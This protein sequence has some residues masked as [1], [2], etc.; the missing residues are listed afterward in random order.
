MEPRCR[1]DC[2]AGP[3]ERAAPRATPP[4]GVVPAADVTY[5]DLYRATDV[6]PPSCDGYRA[7][8]E[9]T[10]GTHFFE[11]KS[12]MKI[13]YSMAA[14]AVV[15]LMAAS[16]LHAADAPALKCPVSGQ[17]AKADKTADFNGG[18]VQFCCEKCPVA[19][20]KDSAKYAGKANLQLVQT[21]QLKQVKCPLTGKAINPEKSVDVE[22]VKVGLCCA[23][24]QGK[25]SKLTGDELINLLFA[26]TTKGFEKAK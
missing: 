4:D 12:E 15:G 26:D 13:R 7:T 25:A 8:V 17:P 10:V 20:A 2:A 9:N 16:V 6:H 14:L 11:R 22:G 24:C 1:R 23:G 21:N 18:K 3:F 19:F 5:E